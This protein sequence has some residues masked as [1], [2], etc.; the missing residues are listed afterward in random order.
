MGLQIG[1]QEIRLVKK[2]LRERIA[3]YIEKQE[4]I[5]FYG[6]VTLV[7]KAG[8]ITIME[9]RQTVEPDFIG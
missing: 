9:I 2:P 5:S 4:Q 8:K 6:T 1:L 3:N 7:F